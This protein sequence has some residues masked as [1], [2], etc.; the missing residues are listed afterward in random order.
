MHFD[1]LLQ[2]FAR[3]R[4]SIFEFAF[5]EYLEDERQYLEYLRIKKLIENSENN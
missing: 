3:L 2:F 1:F 4:L 5:P